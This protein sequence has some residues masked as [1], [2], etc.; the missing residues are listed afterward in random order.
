MFSA[1]TQV[2]MPT[3]FLP[4]GLIDYVRS[5][6]IDL[7]IGQTVNLGKYSVLPP[8]TNIYG[9][10]KDFVTEKSKNLQIVYKFRQKT[11]SEMFFNDFRY[12]LP[13]PYWLKNMKQLYAE[14]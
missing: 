2:A 9:R 14:I 3:L 10:K 7:P 5:D 11:P 1:R 12:M 6:P 4:F 13:K 8:F